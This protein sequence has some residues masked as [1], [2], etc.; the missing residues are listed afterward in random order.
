MTGPGP[1][2]PRGRFSLPRPAAVQAP[3]C[4][5]R[6]QDATDQQPRAKR[7][8]G[9]TATPAPAARPPI[10]PRPTIGRSERPAR[11]RAAWPTEG[12][13]A[14]PAAHADST[15]SP[16]RPGGPDPPAAPVRRIGQG[17]CNPPP[18]L[19][20]PCT[21][22][23]LP[24]RLWLLVAGLRRG[25]R[26]PRRRRGPSPRPHPSPSTFS[27]QTCMMRGSRPAVRANGARVPSTRVVGVLDVS[28][29]ARISGRSVRRKGSIFGFVGKQDPGPVRGAAWRLGRPPLTAAGPAQPARNPRWSCAYNLLYIFLGCVPEAL[30]HGLQVLRPGMLTVQML[31]QDEKRGR[32]HLSRL[33]TELR[34]RK[35]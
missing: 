27:V 20:A 12:R 22:P 33:G 35:T 6:Q 11:R 7:T 14:R 18:S 1:G 5:P 16:A 8:G 15:S 32:P 3:S 21:A 30:G 31:A 4:G 23:F 2:E 28:I 24:L 13:S 26:A 10:S 17:R 9:A 19:A 25:L 29:P 34:L